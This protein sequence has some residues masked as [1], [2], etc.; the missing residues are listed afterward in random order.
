MAQ[1]EQTT[2]VAEEHIPLE[3]LVDLNERIYQDGEVIIAEGSLGKDIYMLVESE[4]GLLVTKEGKK[5]G[6]IT[7]PKEYFGEISSLLN[8]QRTA[9]VT[10]IGRS[11]VQVFP[12]DNLEAT[13]AAYPRLAKKVIDTL[14]SRLVGATEKIIKLSDGKENGFLSS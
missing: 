12:G 8:L 11:V 2:Q 10:S 14:A 13:L 3:S 7:Q 9:T 4:K 1:L 5:V 6:E